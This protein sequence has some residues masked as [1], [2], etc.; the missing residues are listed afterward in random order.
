MG[1]KM[2]TLIGYKQR[3]NVSYDWQKQSEITC[4]AKRDDIYPRHYFADKQPTPFCARRREFNINPS[5]SQS[6]RTNLF[7]LVLGSFVSRL[8]VGKKHFHVV[9]VF[10]FDVPKQPL[11]IC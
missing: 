1:D 5:G 2:R 8:L 11:L 10:V 3:Y 7:E 9:I 6:R 4:S